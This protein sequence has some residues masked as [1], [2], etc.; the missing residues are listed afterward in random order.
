MVFRPARFRARS[1]PA[2]RRAAARAALRTPSQRWR[3]GFSGEAARFAE[4]FAADVVV[5]AT[6]LARPLEGR[7]GAVRVLEAASSIYDSV[8]FRREVTSGERVYLEWDA[9]AFDGM[10]LAGVTVLTTN[11]RGEIIHVAVHH[12]P[13]GAAQRFSAELGTRLAGT[14]DAD[15]CRPL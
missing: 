7:A 11:G 12:R 6:V 8:T 1:A 9:V 4:A 3:S 15:C 2:R 13:L 5:E 14:V 10:A